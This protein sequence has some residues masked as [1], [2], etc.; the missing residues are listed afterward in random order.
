MCLLFFHETGKKNQS[1][2]WLKYFNAKESGKSEKGTQRTNET[3][4]KQIAMMIDLNLSISVIT[5]KENGLN[6]PI[7]RPKLSDWVKQQSPTI[8]CL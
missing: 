6:T 1:I 7:K 3:S 4:E 2:N 8:C 5:L